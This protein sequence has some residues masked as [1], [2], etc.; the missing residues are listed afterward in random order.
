MLGHAEIAR[1]IAPIKVAT[2]EVCH[3]RVMF[4]QF[5]QAKA[6]DFCQVDAV[7]MAGLNEVLAVLLMAQ[8]FKVP[9]CPHAGGV[10]LCELAQ[11]IGMMDYVAISGTMENRMIEYVDHLHEHFRYPVQV[12]NGRYFPPQS[13]GYSIEMKPSSLRDYQYKPQ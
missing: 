8:K 1:Q 3:N 2:G 5:F 7:R 13:P 10:G 4:K 9:V 11:H 6:M 12:Q